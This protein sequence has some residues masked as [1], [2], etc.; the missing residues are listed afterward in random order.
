MLY[1]VITHPR[2]P[3][4]HGLRDTPIRSVVLTNGDIDHV[5]GLLTLREG[6]R[7]DLRKTSSVPSAMRWAL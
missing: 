2:D 5:A 7:F 3:A 1:E 6:Q 4:A